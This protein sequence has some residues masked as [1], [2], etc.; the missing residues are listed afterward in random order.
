MVRSDSRLKIV[1][2]TACLLVLVWDVSAVPNWSWWWWRIAYSIA[3]VGLVA[4]YRFGSDRGL[5]IFGVALGLASLS[6]AFVLG[7]NGDRWSGVAL[8]VLVM[9][10][11][12][13]FPAAR[14]N[15]GR[16]T[17]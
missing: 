1:T 16:I 11:A 8:N 12:V 9:L 7:V 5:S 15:E 14:R 3:A 6:R 13:G 17:R 10:S 4:W 2:M